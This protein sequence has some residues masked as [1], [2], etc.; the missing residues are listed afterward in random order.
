MDDW[1]SL[2]ALIT[3][4]LKYNVTCFVATTGIIK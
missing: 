3:N 4:Q 1:F 2:N